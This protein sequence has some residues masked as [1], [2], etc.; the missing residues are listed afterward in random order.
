MVLNAQC[1]A[2]GSRYA[3]GDHFAG[4]KARCKKCQALFMMPAAEAAPEEIEFEPLPDDDSAADAADDRLARRRRKKRRRQEAAARARTMWVGVAVAAVV[5][6]AGAA[7]VWLIAGGQRDPNLVGNW[8]GA[9]QVQE[10]VATIAKNQ[11]IHPLAKAFG[12]AVIQKAAERMLTVNVEFKKGGTAFFSGNTEAIG[13]SSGSDGPWEVI[14]SEGEVVIVRM[15]P[16]D[17]QFE[18]R[19]AFRDRDT[20]NF[21]RLDQKDEPAI[22]FSRV[23]N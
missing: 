20:F 11:P 5:L 22:V 4:K 1:P 2:C 13:V 19:L 8:Q 10:A 23:K 21:T 14:K 6:L 15:G 3:V 17:K 7:T 9:P 12:Q 16:V 18:A